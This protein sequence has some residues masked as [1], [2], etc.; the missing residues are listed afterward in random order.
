MPS[1]KDIL[2]AYSRAGEDFLAFKLKDMFLK[3]ETPEDVAAHNA[4][5]AEVMLM[6]GEDYVKFYKFLAHSILEKRAQQSMLKIIANS[7][8][9]KG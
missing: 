2:A 9:M 5:Q 6:L 1:G 7:I 8:L 4:M 3:L